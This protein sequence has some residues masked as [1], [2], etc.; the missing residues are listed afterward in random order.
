[1]SSMLYLAQIAANTPRIATQDSGVSWGA[2]IAILGVISTIGVGALGVFYNMLRNLGVELKQTMDK[3][4]IQF[5]ALF[6]RVDDKISKVEVDARGSRKD[7]FDSQMVV[8]DQHSERL[9]KVE[10]TVHLISMRTPVASNPPVG[11]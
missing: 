9:T 10:T 1:M 4:N 5:T 11:S 6:E 2:L 8:K 3:Q 7:L